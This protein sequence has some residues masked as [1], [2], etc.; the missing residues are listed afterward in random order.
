MKS[1]IGCL[2]GV[3]SMEKDNK[4]K[5]GLDVGGDIEKGMK[6][7]DHIP[8]GLPKSREELEEEE[9]SKMPDSA[10][11]RLLRTKGTIPAWFSHVPDHET[12]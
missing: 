2:H 10:F 5:N 6:L 11:T 1:L 8:D 12:D 4:V 3:A 7:H 9:K